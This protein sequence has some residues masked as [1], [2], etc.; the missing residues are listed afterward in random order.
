MSDANQMT[1]EGSPLIWWQWFWLITDE[2]EMVFSAAANDKIAID[3]SR[4]V[5]WLAASQRHVPRQVATA[6][7]LYN[8]LWRLNRQVA[9]QLPIFAR[10]PDQGSPPGGPH[11]PAEVLPEADDMLYAFLELLNKNPEL[12]DKFRQALGLENVM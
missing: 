6:R 2:P 9:Y 11:I 7:D 5:D 10:Q 4:Y 12:R 1:F 3:D 8:T